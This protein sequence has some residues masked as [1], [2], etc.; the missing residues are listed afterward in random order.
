M[1]P[2]PW[3]LRKRESL[4]SVEYWLGVTFLRRKMC[5][6]EIILN[7]M[8]LFGS[9][10]LDASKIGIWSLLRTHLLIDYLLFYVPL[11]N[12]S[13]IW[14]RHQYR[15][16]VAKFRLMLG[17]QG[18]WAGRDLYRATAVVTRDL[19]FFGLIRR[20]APSGA[21]PGIFKGRGPTLSKKSYPKFF[22][23]FSTT[24]KAKQNK[25]KKKT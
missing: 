2:R 4:F 22:F 21:D 25:T 16:R 3:I 17:A 23:S 11:K 8:H 12:I 18:L 20:T 1:T 13:L 10:H 24:R 5:V 7:Y 9:L 14:R 15:W 19:G 6:W